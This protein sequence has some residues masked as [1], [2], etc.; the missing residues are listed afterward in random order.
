MNVVRG[1]PGLIADLL[2]DQAVFGGV[3]NIIKNEALYAAAVHPMSTS[4]DIPVEKTIA[5]IEE[6]ICFSEA[7]LELKRTNKP[8]S[9]F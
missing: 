2:L 7:F 6:A 8:L 5:L 4:K 1:H 9:P 3:G